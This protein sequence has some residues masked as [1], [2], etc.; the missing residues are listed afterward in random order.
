MMSIQERIKNRISH[1]SFMMM[2]I[3]TDV[4]GLVSLAGDLRVNFK[5]KDADVKFSSKDVLQVTPIFYDLVP[6]GENYR[7]SFCFA[8]LSWNGI[9]YDDLALKDRYLIQEAGNVDSM[10]LGLY[11]DL[12]GAANMF[13][14]QDQYIMKARVES[15]S[16]VPYLRDVEKHIVP[17][18]L[19]A[20]FDIFIERAERSAHRTTLPRR[21]AYI[22]LLEEKLHDNNI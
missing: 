17:I 15:V 9:R 4:P 5:F 2:S 14:L 3:V 7:V 10:P 19:T 6:D 13:G 11:H 22:K 20:A 12:D 21:E 16:L 18:D 8:E 1:Q